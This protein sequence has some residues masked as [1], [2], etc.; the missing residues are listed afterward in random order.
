LDRGNSVGQ[1]QP[2]FDGGDP[3]KDNE[4]AAEHDSA[5]LIS[6]LRETYGPEF[7]CGELGTAKLTDVLHRLDKQSLAR[8]IED[9][10]R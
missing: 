1:S 6:T 4:I 3:D 10:L 7:A 5:M 8:L 2:D 9:W